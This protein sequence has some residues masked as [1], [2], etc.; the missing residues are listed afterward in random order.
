MNTHYSNQNNFKSKKNW[1]ESNLV[2]CINSDIHLFIQYTPDFILCPLD[3]YFK[4]QLKSFHLPGGSHFSLL[5]LHSKEH[6]LALG[7]KTLQE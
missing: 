7:R 2:V 3:L 6:I 5:I 4:T 1:D